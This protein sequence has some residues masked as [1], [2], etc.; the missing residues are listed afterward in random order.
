MF[1]SLNLE[2]LV[3]ISRIPI[4]GCSSLVYKGFFIMHY[5][6]PN[7]RLIGSESGSVCMILCP[8]DPDKVRSQSRMGLLEL[9]DLSRMGAL[10]TSCA[11]SFLAR[12]AR[13]Q[14]TA[15]AWQS[16]VERN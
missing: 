13:G 11:S 6:T 9:S 2:N 3:T 10:G 14:D 7:W 8:K 12:E 4:A 15:I 1:V 16:A 5:M